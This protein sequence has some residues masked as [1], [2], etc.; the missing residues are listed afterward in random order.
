MLVSLRIRKIL[1]ITDHA[2]KKNWQFRL[3]VYG[4]LKM[5]QNFICLRKV[6]GCRKLSSKL[7]L[8]DYDDRGK[9]SH[10]HLMTELQ[11][12][13]YLYLKLLT[14]VMNATTVFWV[15][16]MERLVYFFLQWFHLI[17]T[18][19]NTYWSYIK[20]LKQCLVIVHKHMARNKSSNQDHSPSVTLTL[21]LLSAK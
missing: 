4:L 9:V 6:R 5:C 1:K 12:I 20:Q 21:D 19:N 17:L 8:N 2:K 15:K 11:S 13:S 14:L 16:L 3:I 7:L 10:F 18:E